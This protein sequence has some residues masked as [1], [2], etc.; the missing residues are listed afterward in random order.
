M[1]ADQWAALGLCLVAPL[2]ILV[3]CLC[4]VLGGRR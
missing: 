1:S 4:D 3:G 2:L